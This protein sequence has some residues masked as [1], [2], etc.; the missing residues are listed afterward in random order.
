LSTPYIL[1]DFWPTA[2]VIA[3]F[4]VTA[5]TFRL[6]RE[7]QMGD[8][9]A[10]TWLPPADYVNL[11]SLAFTLAAVFVAPIMGIYG[12]P[13]AAQAL[14]LSL[15]LLACYPFALAGHYELFHRRVR[16]PMYFPRQEKI[17]I[18]VT[19]VVAVAYIVLVMAR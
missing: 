7:L 4:Q 2:G 8:H 11:A 13:V 9:G 15:V 12:E 5:F 17:A 10:P 19:V 18:A 14:G 16:T 3:G 1:G 6:N